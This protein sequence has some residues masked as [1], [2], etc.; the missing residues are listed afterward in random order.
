MGVRSALIGIVLS[1]LA[2]GCAGTLPRETATPS[3]PIQATKPDDT[4]SKIAV[5]V[6]VLA[7]VA[8]CTIAFGQGRTQ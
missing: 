8:A 1:S 3:K 4:E 7:G 5:G 6:V 2:T